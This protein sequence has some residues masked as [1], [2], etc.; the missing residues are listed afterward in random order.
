[1]KKLILGVFVLCTM[2]LNAQDIKRII[3]KNDVLALQEY[4]KSKEG[5]D[6][7]IIVRTSNL[8]TSE[9]H[10]FVYAATKN[11]L[12]IIKEFVNSKAIF[13]DF[14]KQLALAFT[15]SI[16]KEKKEVIDYL[17]SLKPNVNEICD[18]RNGHNALME[19][20][21]FGNEELFFKLKDKSEFNLIS[22]EGDNLFH[23]IGEKTKKF[24]A[25]IL[26]ELKNHKDLDVNLINAYGRTPIHYAARSG[27]SD[28]F[29]EL[30]KLGAKPNVLTDLY[31][32]AV[33]GGDL[34]IFEHV[35]QLINKIPFWTT[36]PEMKNKEGDT[37]YPL[38]FA[39]KSNNTEAVKLI[40]K[41]MLTE[42]TTVKH[43][44]QIE[45]VTKILN[46]RELENDQFWPLW[47]ATQ[48]K[49]KELFEFLMKSMVEF[50][51]SKLEYT[52]YNDFVENDV[53]EIAQVY[54]TKFEYRSAKRRFG[55]DYIKNLYDELEIHF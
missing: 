32:D 3:D 18:F 19:A 7:M 9:L 29:F 13:N 12:D 16:S 37:F 11:N 35:C 25:N 55:K 51:N 39:V 41:E 33:V 5:F 30:I 1:M 22:K 28:L 21:F 24:N 26:N 54:F 10:P 47:E 4:L 52:A 27:D 36:F 31:I 38:E 20:T 43:D 45:I 42:V 17:Y 44:D 49:N 6:D 34:K 53:T 14:D 23:L 8:E 50:N 46:S 40:F 2:L 48:A 15:V